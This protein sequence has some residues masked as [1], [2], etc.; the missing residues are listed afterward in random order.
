VLLEAVLHYRHFSV[1]ERKQ[2]IEVASRPSFVP[3][4]VGGYG[5]GHRPFDA[6]PVQGVRYVPK[7]CCEG[8]NAKGHRGLSAASVS[9]D[10]AGTPNASLGQGPAEPLEV[11]DRFSV[12]GP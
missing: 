10:C 6:A 5:T 4:A 12:H 11:F 8:L 9:G 3:V 7:G 2:H 1:G